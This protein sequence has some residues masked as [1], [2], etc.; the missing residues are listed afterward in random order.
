M[1]IELNFSGAF[2]VSIPFSCGRAIID[3]VY[4]STASIDEVRR[5]LIDHDGYDSNIIVTLGESAKLVPLTADQIEK[6]CDEYEI[7]LTG[8]DGC[9][10]WS[11]EE[12]QLVGSFETRSI[13]VL[14]AMESIGAF[15]LEF[16]I[17]YDCIPVI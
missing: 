10:D 1:S 15:E 13:A 16:G 14:D 3:T 6:L 7:V 12:G 4:Y 8:K 9:W 2:D 17:E 5:G 11:I